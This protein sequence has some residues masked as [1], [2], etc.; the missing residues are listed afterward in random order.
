MRFGVNQYDKAI[1]ALLEGRDQLQPDSLCCRICHDS[2]HQ[3][4]ECGHNPLYA[5]AVCNG[6][7]KRA[8]ELHDCMHEVSHRGAVDKTL[9]DDLH[10]FLHY[11]I[12]AEL[13]MGEMVGPRK[14]M[15]L[16]SAEAEQ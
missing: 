7:V 2:G 12:G 15:F 1:E 9:S 3:A 4:W 5:M 13:H 11:V 10:A 6:L 8:N 16:Q 14:V